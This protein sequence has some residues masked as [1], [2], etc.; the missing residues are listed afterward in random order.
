MFEN[1]VFMV[2]EMTQPQTHPDEIDYYNELDLVLFISD[3]DHGRKHFLFRMTATNNLNILEVIFKSF[4][5][6]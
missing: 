2:K 5:G 6:V 1:G 4:I 3:D